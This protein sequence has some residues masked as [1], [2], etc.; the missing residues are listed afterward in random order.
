MCREF[1]VGDEW[2]TAKEKW[3]G[4]IGTDL[5]VM[6]K[7]SDFILLSFVK[8]VG[9]AFPSSVH[10]CLYNNSDSFWNEKVLPA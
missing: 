8:L 6:P 5:N 9:W 7:N 2:R 3:C 1:I 10:T 4:P